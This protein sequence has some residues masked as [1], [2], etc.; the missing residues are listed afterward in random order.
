VEKLHELP[1]IRKPPSMSMEE[2]MR[3][4]ADWVREGGGVE[5]LIA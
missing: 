4:L 2:G 5:R 1:L 3:G